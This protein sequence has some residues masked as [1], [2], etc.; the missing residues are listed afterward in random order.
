MKK[1]ILLLSVLVLVGG[2]QFNVN[3]T[4][5]F[6]D[7][8]P[9]NPDVIED[10]VKEGWSVYRNEVLGIEFEYKDEWG[11]PEVSP[12][13]YLTRLKDVQEEYGS[14]QYNYFKDQVEIRF[15]NYN[16]NY[17]LPKLHFYN[18]QHKGDDYPNGLVMGEGYVDNFDEVVESGDICEYRFS[19]DNEGFTATQVY[20]ECTSYDY[21]SIIYYTESSRLAGYYN[22]NFSLY[23]YEP[24]VNGFYENLLIEQPVA[25]RQL[26]SNSYTQPDEAVSAVIEQA[27]EYEKEFDVVYDEVKS[28][29][30]YLLSS[31]EL[32]ESSGIIN[33]EIKRGQASNKDHQLIYDYYYNIAIGDLGSAYDLNEGSETLAQFREW[34]KDTYNAEVYGLNQLQNGNYEFRVNLYE[35]NKRPDEYRVVKSVIDG[36]LKSVSSVQVLSEVKYNDDLSAMAIKE[37]SNIKVLVYKDGKEILV[38]SVETMTGDHLTEGFIR[39]REVSEF[40][41]DGNYLEVIEY[42]WEWS[43]TYLYNVVT[44]EKLD[45]NFEFPEFTADSKYIYDCSVGDIGSAAGFK[46]VKLGN[47]DEV[48]VDM[49]YEDLPEG[50][51]GYKCTYDAEKALVEATYV[52][53]DEVERTRLVYDLLAEDFL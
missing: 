35:H 45:V 2:C 28:D 15:T 50:S 43:S 34:Y 44:E 4:V 23:S 48:L 10:S 13:K 42:G 22:Y 21:T 39:A 36:K 52:V 19:Y 47:P 7:L 5:D 31:I 41:E 18:D 25:V 46:I 53:Y 11:T 8:E 6:D 51:Y 37:G 32:I 9:S 17:K 33:P 40:S 3:G 27:R 49:T 12:Y 1:I 38:E 29:F 14:Q 24:L 20:D 30:E 26:R 16:S